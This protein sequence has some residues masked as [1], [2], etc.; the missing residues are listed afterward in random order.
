MF[1]F[2]SCNFA[3]IYVSEQLSVKMAAR[4]EVG[5]LDQTAVLVCMDSLALNVKEVETCL[6]CYYH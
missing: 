5:A 4:M 2:L 3:R 6:L 1:L